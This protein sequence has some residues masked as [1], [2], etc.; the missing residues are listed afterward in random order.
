MGLTIERSLYQ[1]VLDKLTTGIVE[2]ITKF[3]P[4]KKLLGEHKLKGHLVVLP[5][6][7]TT[8]IEGTKCRV[9]LC[10]DREFYPPENKFI[11]VFLKERGLSYPK[12][13]LK[14][15]KSKLIFYGEIKQIPIQID[16]NLRSDHILIARA[17]GYI[18]KLC[19]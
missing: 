18:K 19:E 13:F 4:G 11:P 1:L 7:I 6:E 8:D 17:V 14:F 15:I 16:K 3:I 10:S 9:V 12:E 5:N 2:K